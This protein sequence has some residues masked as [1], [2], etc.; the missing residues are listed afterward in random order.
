MI[1]LL[2]FHFQIF[3][4]LF[5]VCIAIST[6]INRQLAS[7]GRWWRE[8]ST[9]LSRHFVSSTCHRWS[10]DQDGCR[11]NFVLVLEDHWVRPW[12]HPDSDSSCLL[13]HYSWLEGMQPVGFGSCHQLILLRHYNFL[14]VIFFLRD[15]SMVRAIK[16]LFVRCDKKLLVKLL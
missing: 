2:S 14:F 10:L 3:L 8:G 1:A 11:Q 5:Q 12:I 4:E 7:H 13:E 16:I 9:S 6:Y 15:L